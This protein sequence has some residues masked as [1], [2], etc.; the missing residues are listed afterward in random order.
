MLR[1]FTSDPTWVKTET[2]NVSYQRGLTNMA[3][4]FIILNGVLSR[5]AR[6]PAQCTVLVTSDGKDSL[7]YQAA[8]KGAGAHGQRYTDVYGAGI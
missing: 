3:Q 6:E 5:G 7:R 8:E 1:A 2:L 4:G